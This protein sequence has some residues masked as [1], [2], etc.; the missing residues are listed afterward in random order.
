MVAVLRDRNRPYYD[1]L[2]L[3]TNEELND[4]IHTT[5][6]CCGHFEV[7]DHNHFVFYI[8]QGML[9]TN[10]KKIN[11]QLVFSQRQLKFEGQ[12]DRI[13]KSKIHCVMELNRH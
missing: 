11:I 12:F 6:S 5:R 7:I 1:N 3:A 8:E 10:I 9:E 2:V 13:D 4:A